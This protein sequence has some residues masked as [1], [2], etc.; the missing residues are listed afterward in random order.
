MCAGRG[1]LPE[2]ERRTN[3]KPRDPPGV[4]PPRE[5]NRDPQLPEGW[6][7]VRD[8]S[9]V[10]DWRTGELSISFHALMSQEIF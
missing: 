5:H 7:K 4:M 9:H 10:G 1:R 3:G 6:N 2:G 8:R